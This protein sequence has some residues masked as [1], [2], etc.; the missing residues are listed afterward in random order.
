[1][2]ILQVK[3]CHPRNTVLQI[4][5]PLHWPSH[6]DLVTQLKKLEA[7]HHKFQRR[8]LGIMW[9]DKVRNEEIRRKTG[10]RKLELI[11]KERRLRWLGTYWEWGTP[12]YLNRL[13]SGNWGATRESRDAQ[14]KIGWT[15]S[16][17]IWRTW[18]SPGMKPKNWRQTEQNG[19]NVPCGPMHPSRCGM[20]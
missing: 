1:M 7:A 13:Y 15:S 10:L 16:D 11:I 20:N 17:D 4:W 12:E 19:V 3:K 9:K 6:T 14:E 2:A 5:T 18:T 8:L